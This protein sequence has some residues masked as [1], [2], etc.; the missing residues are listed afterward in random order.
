M[1]VLVVIKFVEFSCLNKKLKENLYGEIKIFKMLC[2]LYIVVFYDCVELVMY[3]NLIMEY[4]EFG[5]LLLFIKKWE[6][7]IIYLVICDIV[8]R[9]FIEYN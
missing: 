1:G 6:K 5:D 9:Y 2:Y 8:C 3:I 7:L 4:C